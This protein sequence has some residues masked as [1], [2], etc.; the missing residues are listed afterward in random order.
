MGKKKSY[1]V[2]EVE[3]NND[4]TEHMTRLTFTSQDYDGNFSLYN[5]EISNLNELKFKI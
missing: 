1:N 4:Q 3:A 5:R 2:F